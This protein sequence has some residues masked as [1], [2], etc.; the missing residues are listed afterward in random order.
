MLIANNINCQYTHSPRLQT[1]NDVHVKRNIHSI[2][3]LL[4][5]TYIVNDRCPLGLCQIYNIE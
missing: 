5:P 3:K 2:V 4:I 1:D